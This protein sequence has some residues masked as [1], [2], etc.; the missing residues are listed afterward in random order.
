MSEGLPEPVALMEGPEALPRD[1]GELVFSSPWEARA[2]ALAVA[3]VE[4][5]DLPWDAFRQRLMQAVADAPDRPYYESWA[6]ALEMLLVS[7]DLATRE[8]LDSAAPAQRPS[9]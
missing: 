2:V 4:R 8:A 6:R 5:L 9:L 1:N 7:L 3:L